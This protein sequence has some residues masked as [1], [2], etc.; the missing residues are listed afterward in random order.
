MVLVFSLHF[1]T[2]FRT[3]PKGTEMFKDCNSMW[4]AFFPRAQE[5]VAVSK[6]RPFL[7]RSLGKNGLRVTLF[8]QFHIWHLHNH[9]ADLVRRED[10]L[11][12]AGSASRACSPT[13][14]E[15]WAASLLRPEVFGLRDLS[16]F[17]SWFLIPFPSLSQRQGQ[18]S[19]TQVL[20]RDT[21][22][23]KNKL[24]FRN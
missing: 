10:Q 24:T 20:V 5:L 1:H 21:I 9:S 7:Y 14:T 11:Q 2:R 8:T 16:T 23:Q 4:P 19:K 15:H 18:R 12:S 3:H 13:N 17:A 22:K 6:N